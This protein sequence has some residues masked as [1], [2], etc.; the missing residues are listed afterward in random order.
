[1]EICRMDYRFTAVLIIM[2]TL[3]ALFGGPAHSKNEYLNDNFRDCRTGEIDVSVE[4]RES[5][6]N[7][8]NYNAS[9]NYDNFDEDRNIRLTYRKYLGAACTDE[10]K[11]LQM[12]NM[13]LKQLMELMKKCDKI[14]KNPSYLRNPE[15]A[16]LV[17]KCFG[18]VPIS[19]QDSEDRPEG[20]YW[21]NLKEDYIKENPGT[22]MGEDGS[23]PK[24]KGLKIPKYLTDEDIILPLP[25]PAE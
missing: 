13:Q 1:M 19:N 4:Q 5:D 17:K 22:Y 7:H 24:K 12:E 15:F 23:K 14:N 18:I 3:L 9:S 6:Y 20:N 11:K 16:L 10:Y 2:I 8:R 21:E 25:K